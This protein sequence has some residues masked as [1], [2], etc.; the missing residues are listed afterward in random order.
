MKTILDRKNIEAQRL[1]TE[2]L[3]RFAKASNDGFNVVHLRI[4]ETGDYVT[5]PKTTLELFMSILSNMA[6]GR[7]VSIIPSDSELTT[8]QAADMLNPS[9]GTA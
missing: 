5:L 1:A 2:S 6:E 9:Q 7:S 8:Q 3:H 4:E